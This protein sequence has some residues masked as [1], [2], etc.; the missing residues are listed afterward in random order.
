MASVKSLVEN[1]RAVR[2]HELLRLHP[3]YVDKTVAAG[4]HEA[5]SVI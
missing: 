5:L 1:C 4:V 3:I 2:R